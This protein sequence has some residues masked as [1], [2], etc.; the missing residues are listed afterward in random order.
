MWEAIVDFFIDKTRDTRIKKLIQEGC[1]TE[2]LEPQMCPECNSE[3]LL[4]DN[5]EVDET[6]IIQVEVSCGQCGCIVGSYYDEK[7]D[8]SI[9]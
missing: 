7:W 8:E 1:I 9:F 2:E 5:I 3:M 6:E 4:W